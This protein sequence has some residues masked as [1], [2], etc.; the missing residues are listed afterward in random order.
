MAA[1]PGS[2]R[3]EGGGPA[4]ELRERTSGDDQVP[5]VPGQGVAYRQRAD[6]GD[7]QDVDGPSEGLGDAVGRGQ[8]GGADGAG[9]PDA[10]R[11]M[12][13]LLEKPVAA[14]GLR[15]P[16]NLAT[17]PGTDQS[18]RACTDAVISSLRDV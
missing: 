3:S 9:S 5:G 2:R 15:S 12:G 6:R 8:C 16:G 11:T 4:A 17:P 14:N 18:R 1:G 7:V 13:R 10:K